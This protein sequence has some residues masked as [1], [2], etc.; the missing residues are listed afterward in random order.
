MAMTSKTGVAGAQFGRLLQNPSSGALALVA[1][2]AVAMSMAFPAFPTGTNAGNIANQMV[3][4]VLLALGMTV[5]LITGGIDLSVGSV[6]GLSAGIGAYTITTG[7]PLFLGLLA[8]VA[9]GGFLGFINGLLITRLGLP[10]FIATLAML[11]VARGVL[12]LWTNGVPLTGYMLPEYYIISGLEQPFGFLTVPML[13]AIAAVLAVGLLLKA[14]GFGRHAYGIGSNPQAALLSGV[15][16]NRI[17]VT[18]YVI[19][20][21]TAGV[22]GMLMAGRTMTVAPTMGIGFELSA[23]AAAVI[24]GAALTGGRGTAFGALTGALVLSITANAINISGVSSAWQQVVIGAVLLLAVVFDRVSSLLR[25]RS[26]RLRIK[27]VHV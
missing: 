2:L 23:I 1:V 22:A 4:V 5:V 9:A 14:T 15:P 16:V 25:E 19:S 12:F 27:P 11:G 13:L 18:A 6:M 17:K 7:V 20:G 10:D 3:F 21:L 8:A 24:G 26:A